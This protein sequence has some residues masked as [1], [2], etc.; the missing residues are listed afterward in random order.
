M[1]NSFEK[2][3]KTKKDGW[4]VA[5]FALVEVE[6]LWQVGQATHLRLTPKRRTTTPIL[7]RLCRP[8]GWQTKL[9][10]GIGG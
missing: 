1:S 4:L 6:M 8:K 10:L 2:R 9:R 5:W 3:P 7:S